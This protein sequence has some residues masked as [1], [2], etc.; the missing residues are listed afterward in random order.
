MQVQYQPSRVVDKAASGCAKQ[1][2]IAHSAFLIRN[3][4]NLCAPSPPPPPPQTANAVI[5]DAGD[6]CADDYNYV[7]ALDLRVRTQVDKTTLDCCSCSTTA[8]LGGQSAKKRRASRRE[9]SGDTVAGRQRKRTL[10][11]DW[12]LASLEW[13]F[14]RN[15]YLT[16]DD[17]LRVAR[18]LQLDQLQVKTWFQVS[19][20]HL[21]NKIH[22]MNDLW[23]CAV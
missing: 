17:R 22:K 9:A 10:F 5:I 18:T 8:T 20:A 4:I 21:L 7:G 1:D 13:R 16:S 11:A 14:A 19:V 2:N 3:L 23:M 6:V 12:Q 15:K